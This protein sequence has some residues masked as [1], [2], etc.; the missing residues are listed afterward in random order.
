MG[1]SGIVTSGKTMFKSVKSNELDYLNTNEP[2]YWPTDTSKVPDLLNYFIIKDIYED[3][4]KSALLSNSFQ[5]THL[6]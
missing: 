3:I 4:P 2:T 6:L 5:I 1:H